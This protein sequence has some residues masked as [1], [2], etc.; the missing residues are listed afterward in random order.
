M[1]LS[2]YNELFLLYR[3]YSVEMKSIEYVNFNSNDSSINYMSNHSF[4]NFSIKHT[5]NTYNRKV[6][7]KLNKDGICTRRTVIRIYSDVEG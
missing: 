2:P 3:N 1:V 6:K 4:L 5:Y 7:T